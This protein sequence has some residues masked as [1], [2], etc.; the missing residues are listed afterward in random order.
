MIRGLRNFSL[1]PR[2]RTLREL[3]VTDVVIKTDTE[4]ENWLLFISL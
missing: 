2:G 4:Y 3:S 1:R